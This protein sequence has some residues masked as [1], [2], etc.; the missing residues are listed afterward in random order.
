M[1]R[2]ALMLVAIVVLAVWLWMR[3][4][5]F[6]V[7]DRVALNGNLSQR[8]TIMAIP[9]PGAYDVQFDGGTLSTIPGD[10]LVKI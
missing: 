3:S 7:G 2:N 1:N 5:G 8:G 9:A 10:S 6:A 4:R